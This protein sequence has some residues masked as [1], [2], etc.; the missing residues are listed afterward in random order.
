M[1][2]KELRARLEGVA[3]T[4]ITPFAQDGKVDDVQLRHHV[5][6]LV[7][8]GIEILV[9]NGNTGEFY[10]LTLDECRHALEVVADEVGS[11]AL[12]VAGIAHDPQTAVAMAQHAE[13]TGAQAVMVHNPVHPYV[14]AAGLKD[15]YDRIAESVGIGIVPYVRNPLIDIDVLSHIARHENMV[16]CKYAINDL[17]LFGDVVRAIPTDEAQV[18]WLCGTAE[19]W[20]PF[21]FSVGARGFTS[22]LANLIP[23]MPL[24]MLSA[25]RENDSARVMQL[26]HEIRPFEA[27]RARKNSGLNVSV[28]KE[29]M[30]MLDMPTGG[31]RAPIAPLSEEERAELRRILESWGV[32][33]AA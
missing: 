8:H 10:S 2:F 19:A 6:F 1:D 22:G 15:Y 16:A 14:V 29:G 30:E 33:A 13:R 26:W 31:V 5:R 3:V 20:A 9:T 24:N 18:A 17:Q 25:L 21:Y 4:H 27:L 7:D 23:T 28:V 32:L 11:D 12:L